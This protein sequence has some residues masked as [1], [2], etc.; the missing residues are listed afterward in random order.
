MRH[1]CLIVLLSLASLTAKASEESTSM[2]DSHTSE[3]I[4]LMTDFARRTGLDSDRPPQRYLWT[5]AFAVCNFLGLAST[6]GDQRYTELA[7]ALVDQVH[8]TLGRHRDDDSRSGWISGLDEREG[9]AHPTRGG[10][11]IGKQLPERNQGGAIDERLEWERDGQ[12]FHY[13]TRWMHALDQASRSTGDSRYNAWAR[14]L[15]ATAHDAFTYPP[16]V[17]LTPRMFWKMSIDLRRPL[18]TSMGQLDPLDGYVTS[19]QLRA[20][21][22]GPPQPVKEP[23]LEEVTRRYAEML[24]Q[25]RLAGPDPLGIGG[26]LIDAWRLTQLESEEGERDEGLV[27]QLLGAA[28]SGLQFYASSGELQ[29]PAGYRLAFRE[30]GLAIGLHAVERMWEETV[31]RRIGINPETREK[32][33]ALMRYR[34]LGRE[35][36]TFWRDP[37]NQ[38]AGTWTEHLD[39]NEVMLATSLAPDGYL[40][41]GSE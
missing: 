17:G 10:L 16:P 25:S 39:I 33:E 22:A 9:E 35:I 24:D 12:Y 1:G 34:P 4:S 30:L 3:V 5:D 23:D 19:L 7:L 26:L 40:L 27:G 2:P 38:R 18:V 28:L 32:L 41:L 36:E 21:A 14:E 20:T 29:A 11:R 6:T 13:L 8:H 31:R 37:G 15:A